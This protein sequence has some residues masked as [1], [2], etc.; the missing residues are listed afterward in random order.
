[1]IRI[2]LLPVR[3]AR[4]RADIQQQALL[5]GFLLVLAVGVVGFMHMSIRGKIA[6]ANDSVVETQAQ[7]EKFEPQLEKVEEYKKKRDQVQAKLDVI[8]TLDAMNL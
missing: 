5:L 7:I 2:N 6:G 1:M 3:E 4:R 8:R